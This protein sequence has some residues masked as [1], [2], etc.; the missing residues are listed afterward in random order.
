MN[1]RKVTTL[2]IG[3]SEN[4]DR[5][6]NMAIKL[7]LKKGYQVAAIGQ[8]TGNVEQIP[9]IKDKE[10][11]SNIDTVTLYINPKIQEEYIEYIIKLKPNRIIFNPGTEN[12]EFKALAESEGIKTEYACTLVLLNLGQY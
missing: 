6:S 5:Y 12:D 2:V 7:L 4:P 3:A 10:N 11:F 9:I 8:K 1:D